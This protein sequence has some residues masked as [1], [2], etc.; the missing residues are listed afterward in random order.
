MQVISSE[1]GI[2]DV[3]KWFLDEQF[4]EIEPSIVL[5]YD[6]SHSSILKIMV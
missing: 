6:Y 1:A 2:D 5:N 3:I 4:F